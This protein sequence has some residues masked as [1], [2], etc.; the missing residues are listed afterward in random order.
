MGVAFR[1]RAHWS[2]LAHEIVSRDFTSEKHKIRAA[3][4]EAVVRHSLSNISLSRMS[5]V[6]RIVGQETSLVQ[7]TQ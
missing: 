4:D 6:L 3:T 2:Y 7:L 1:L 5:I